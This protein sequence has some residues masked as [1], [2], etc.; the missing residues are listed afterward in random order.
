M[1]VPQAH[2]P[3]ASKAVG[4]RVCHID[5]ILT[6]TYQHDPVYGDLHRV[7][8]PGSFHRLFEFSAHLL[9]EF[10]GV[11]TSESDGFA[12]CFYTKDTFPDDQ[13][14]VHFRHINVSAVILS[15]YGGYVASVNLVVTI[16]LK[17]LQICFVTNLTHNVDIFVTPLAWM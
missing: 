10:G 12:V 17:A 3:R 6:L 7:R 2:G 4:I 16:G 11:A 8:S 14:G 5:A 13:A 15:I 1:Q 9:V